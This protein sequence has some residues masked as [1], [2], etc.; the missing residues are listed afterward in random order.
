[1]QRVAEEYAERYG[2]K[3]DYIHGDEAVRELGKLPDCVA[4]ELP[5]VSKSGFTEYIIKNGILPK[6]TFSMGSAEEKRYYLEARII[7]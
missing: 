1:M 7:G 4:I 5:P 6:K 3:I 2:A